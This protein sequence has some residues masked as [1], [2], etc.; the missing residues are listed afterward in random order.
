V[1]KVNNSEKKML[2]TTLALATVVGVTTVS[3][4]A[5]EVPITGNVQS[6]CSIYTTTAGVYGSPAPDTLSTAPADGGVHPIVR[7]DVSQAGYYIAKITTPN[8]FS[9]SPVLNDVVNFTGA[10]TV[11]QVSDAGMSA[12]ETNKVAYNNVTEFD[13]TVA[14]SVWF[15]STSQAE[16][17]VDKS[18]PGGTYRAVVLAECIAK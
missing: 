17:G 9:T 6:K 8:S 10:T 12:Y 14:G 11:S 13:L 1:K 16:Y 7:V 2:K 4:F 15:Q 3:A 5:T 18:F